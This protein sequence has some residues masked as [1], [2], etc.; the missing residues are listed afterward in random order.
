MGP[1][2]NVN[3]VR[4][5]VLLTNNTDLIQEFRSVNICTL[6]KNDCFPKKKGHRR[7]KVDLFHLEHTKINKNK[8]RKR[9][10]FHFF[11][12]KWHFFCKHEEFW[13]GGFGSLINQKRVYLAELSW[14]SRSWLTWQDILQLLGREASQDNQKLMRWGPCVCV[15][16]CAEGGRGEGKRVRWWSFSSVSIFTGSGAACCQHNSW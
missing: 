4:W 10:F 5:Y 2:L 7:K 11:N 1:G 14:C 16:V 8:T 13:W 6:S 3:S 15:C 12:E 9:R